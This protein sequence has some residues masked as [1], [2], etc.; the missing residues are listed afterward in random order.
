MQRSFEQAGA[1]ALTLALGLAAPSKAQAPAPTPFVDLHATAVLKLGQVADWVA[2]T[3]DAVWV[4]S[5][6]PNAVH[7]IDPR[8]NTRTASVDLPGEPCAGLATGFGALW[9]P[10]CGKTPRLAQVDLA[11]HRLL[12]ILPIGP[13]LSEGGIATSAD[14]VWIVTDTKGSLARIDPAT[15]AVRQTVA[16]PPG[17]YNLQHADGRIYA[18][19]VAGAA[20]TAVD[21]ASG[22]VLASIPTGPQPRFL[23][24]GGGFVWTLNQGDGTLTRISATTLE[25]LGTVA[26]KT[27][28]PGGDIV[29]HD[30]KV[31]TTIPGTPLSVTDAATDQ[32][33]H[34][35]VGP[36]GDSLNIG[37][38]AIWITDYG[39]GTIARI[40]LA[41]TG[42]R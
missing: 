12:K 29:F 40:P 2:V 38:G 9:V 23:A 5:K 1:V 42:I 13:P 25:V 20:L 39:R 30:G 17:S 21:A 33:L 7:R 41:R 24:V 28:G 14:S 35:W 15:G 19:Q 27:P 6:G 8:T 18:T 11:T 16:L 10:V 34:Q 22:K 3:D 26:L 31:W 32:V 36:G 4:G 37:H